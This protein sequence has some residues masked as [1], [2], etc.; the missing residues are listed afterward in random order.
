MA[1]ADTGKKLDLSLVSQMEEKVNEI[2]Q[3]NK[4]VKNMEYF[5]DFTKMM[6]TSRADEIAEEKEKGKKVIGS[7]C[8]F[9]P[10]ELIL[11]AGAI[12]IRHC[13]GFQ[14]TILPAEEILPRNFCPLIKSAL[15]FC[16]W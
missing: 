2:A 12:P 13:A 3:A 14:D 1:Q 9:V 6:Y 11:A 5:Y 7:F 16:R 15:G 4:T 8:N 10:E